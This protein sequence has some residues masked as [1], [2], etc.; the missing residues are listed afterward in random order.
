M[1]D[2]ILSKDVYENVCIKKHD[3]TILSSFSFNPSDANITDRFEEFAAGME[4]L[5]IIISE[6]EKEKDYKKTKEMLKKINEAI[7]QKVNGLLNEDVAKD[8]FKVMGPLSPLPSGDYYFTFIVEQIGIK[9]QNAT[10][11]RVKKIEMKV[12]KHTKK[13]HG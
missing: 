6:Y 3:G 9:I 7:Y 4:E 5:E 8:I 11:Q 1:S 12:K 10:G 13:Y 2:I